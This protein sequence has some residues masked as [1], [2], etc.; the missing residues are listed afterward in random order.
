MR[1]V[2]KATGLNRDSR[3]A[4]CQQSEL[5]SFSG[6]TMNCK[7]SGSCAFY[8]AH[9][10][11]SNSK[12]YRLLIEGYCEGDLHPICR[13]VQ[14]EAEFGKKASEDLAPNGYLLGTHKKLKIENTRKHK[15]FEVTNGLCL[16]QVLDTERT[17]S[18]W[19]VDISEGGIKLE[20][21]IN[22][23]DQ[24]ICSE[25]RHLKIL[26]HSVKETPFPFD[27]EV[28]KIVWQNELV[29]GCSFAPSSL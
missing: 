14:Y 27:K 26:G 20:M 7:Y 15:R 29:V 12:Q 1:Q 21:N 18:A 13:R 2:R 28:A 3:V 8:N 17:F 11:K 4:H 10:H 16:L 9:S 25:K 23:K 5:I 24:N 19:V 22:P 6:L